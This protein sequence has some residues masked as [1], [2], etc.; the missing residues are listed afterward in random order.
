MRPA[1][2][3]VWAVTFATLLFTSAAARQI[4]VSVPT[5]ASDVWLREGPS[6]SNAR[7]TGLQRGTAV[8]EIASPDA[9][10]EERSSRWVRVFVL[11]GRAEGKEGWVWGEFVTC[12][13][14]RPW[15]E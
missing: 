6:T 15:L 8:V 1:A 10:S 11:E 14:T 12:C 5:I 7:I 3:A 13:T 4:T 9:L 2:M